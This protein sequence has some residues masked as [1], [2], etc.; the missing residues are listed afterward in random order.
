MKTLYIGCLAL[1]LCAPAQAI[2]AELY[3]KYQA[4][5]ERQ[6]A[7]QGQ[8]LEQARAAL[9]SGD[10]DTAQ[11]HLEIARNLA[12]APDAVSALEQEIATEKN[13]QEQERLAQERLAREQQERLRAEEVAVRY[14]SGHSTYGFLM[15]DSEVNDILDRAYKA[16]QQ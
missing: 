4:Y 5:K 1:A 2:D 3:Q 10:L 15:P 7:T 11:Q 12:Y 6:Q 8:E 9:R 14:R 16:A 13:R